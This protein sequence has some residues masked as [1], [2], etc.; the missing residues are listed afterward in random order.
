LFIYFFFYNLVR[1]FAASTNVK[2]EVE[3]FI[4]GKSVMI[5]AGSA[6]IQACE[7]AGADVNITTI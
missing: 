4:D 3:V 7:K 1:A 2:E 6:L 5:E